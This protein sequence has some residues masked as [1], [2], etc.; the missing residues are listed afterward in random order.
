MAVDAP[1]LEFIGSTHPRR[2][3]PRRHSARGPLETAKE[4]LHLEAQELC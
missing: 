1:V 2:R 4:H 3:F